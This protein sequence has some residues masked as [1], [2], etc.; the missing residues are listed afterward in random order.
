MKLHSA[1]L[2]LEM[3]CNEIFT[4]QYCPS[5][6]SGAG[7]PIQKLLDRKWPEREREQ[8]SR[9]MRLAGIEREMEQE[10]ENEPC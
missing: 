9:F 7:I 2:C 10:K 1:K 6:T 3:D 5:C 8:D 4:G